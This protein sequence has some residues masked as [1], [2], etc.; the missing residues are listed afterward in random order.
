MSTWR[1][2]LISRRGAVTVGAAAYLSAAIV[3]AS[4][5][6]AGGG[7]LSFACLVCT[8]ALAVA[9]LALAARPE[10]GE[11]R[12]N[13]ALGLLLVVGS[14]PVG[15]GSRAFGAFGGAIVTSLALTGAEGITGPG[16]IG[17]GASLDLRAARKIAV[18]LWGLTA[19]A[20]VAHALG[21]AKNAD[22]SWL[23][24][25]MS[26][27]AGLAIVVALLTRATR[28][29]LELGVPAQAL[30]ATIAL[31]AGMVTGEGL[32]IVL[33]VPSGRGLLFGL[34]VGAIAAAEISALPDPARVLAVAR[35]LAV[36]VLVVTPLVGLTAGLVGEATRGF[37]PA[38]VA[39]AAVAVALGMGA[40]RLDGVFFEG[41]SRH[42]RAAERALASVRLLDPDDLVKGVLGA[43][44]EPCGAAGP[45][46]VFY[47]HD[48]EPAAQRVDTGG[49]LT[50]SEARWPIELIEV[51]RGEPYGTARIEVLRAVD[52]RRPD[53]RL[54]LRFMEEE[55]IEAATVVVREGEPIGLV[56]VPERG[57]R[58]RAS[59]EEV[60]AL[61]ALA[62]HLAHVGATH[63]RVLRGLAREEALRVELEDERER[64]ARLEHDLELQASRSVAHATRLA[65]PA[66]IGIYSAGA[67]LSYDALER[68][69]KAQAPTFVVARAGID[70]VPYVARAHLAGPRA[71][72]PL[73]VVDGTSTREHDLPRWSDPER[74]P[75]ALA[76]GGVLLLVDAPC[77]PDTVQ[78]LVA[79]ALAERRPPWERAQ[80]ID[81]VLVA[82]AAQAPA[83]LVESGRLD[84]ALA[85][86]LGAAIDEAVVLPRLADRPEDLRA[87]VTDRLAREGLRQLGRPVGI[88]DAAFGL[89]CEHP[90]EGE[91]AELALLA[92]KLVARATGDVIRADDVRALGLPTPV[93]EEPSAGGLKLVR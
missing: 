18:A 44:K 31:L 88:D 53:L 54:A 55:E 27:L 85:A 78:R 29:Y 92:A 60:V 34:A 14:I 79:R 21:V 64:S 48:P 57:R 17:R 58:A 63:A 7:L 10:H 51:A 6:G 84:E 4:G 50:A 43:L 28:G 82:T 65:R 69:A 11:R 3:R 38:A 76:D 73:V 2:R 36:L 66:A 72:S 90:F 39:A 5:G 9:S 67:R 91:D 16:G 24:G 75:L 26:A 89:L 62:D 40:R 25:G 15:E 47:T 49:Y 37:A 13:G 80:P 74:S 1:E 93:R 71:R 20:Y 68:R 81:V 22:E 87:I 59:L 52:V 61:K 86:R 33:H 46:P 12:A 19:A 83:E 32:A 42:A 70:P 77:L 35:R 23:G 30:A 41:Q 8:L 45:S 56:T